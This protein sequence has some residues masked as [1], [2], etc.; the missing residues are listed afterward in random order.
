MLA[1]ALLAVVGPFFDAVGEEGDSG[2]PG[3]VTGIGITVLVSG[4]VTFFLG[5]ARYVTLGL[6]AALF[7]L[8][9]SGDLA[10]D[11]LYEML[12]G[13]SFVLIGLLSLIGHRG[14]RRTRSG[15]GA[16]AAGEASPGAR[17]EAPSAPAE[18]PDDRAPRS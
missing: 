7:F 17:S 3:V 6:L 13:G 4:A 2:T 9:Y 5:W 8:A 12:A 14:A 10:D 1:G 18:G 15:R 16:S 11:V